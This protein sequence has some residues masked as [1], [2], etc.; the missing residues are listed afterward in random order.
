M[1]KIAEDEIPELLHRIEEFQESFSRQW[2]RDNKA[3]GFEI[4]LIRLGG[5]KER[6]VYAQRQILLWLE[7]GKDRVEE[8]EEKRLPFAYVAVTDASKANVNVWSTIV[9]P[10]VIG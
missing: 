2:H 6:L 10:G 8:L 5:L 4:Q 9:S 1:R 7:G 3:L